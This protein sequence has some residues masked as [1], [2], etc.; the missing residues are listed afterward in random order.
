[1]R[2]MVTGG[3]GFVGRALIAH[4]HAGRQFDIV[5][6]LRQA[7]ELP[8][9]TVRPVGE[10]GPDTDWHAALEGI[11]TVI[12]CAGRAHRREDSAAD[13]LAAFRSVNVAGTVRLAEQAAAA[14]VR[15]LVFLSSV[16]VHGEA[17]PGQPFRETDTLAPVDPYGVSKAE[18]ELALRQVEKQTGLEVVII[19]PPLIYG[20]NPKANMLRLMRWVSSGLPLPFGAIHNRRSLVS[21][22]NLISAILAALTHTAAAGRT[23]LVS[24]QTDISTPDLVRLMAEALASP[25]R[26]W[27][28]P[29]G[30]LKLAGGLTGRSEEIQRLVGSL[31]VDSGLISRELDWRPPQALRAGIAEMAAQYRTR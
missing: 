27:P 19:R 1:M 24:D 10:I 2:V 7:G 28:I 20:P 13:P 5:A 31:V 25:A 9:A 8:G 17:T 14:G 18:A 4:M 12:H 11:E 23:Y 21:L 29:A 6:A 3:S 15:R 22:K 26:L 30:F 16:K